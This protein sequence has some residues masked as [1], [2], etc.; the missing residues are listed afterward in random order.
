[1]RN[2]LPKVGSTL[3]AFLEGNMVAPAEGTQIPLDNKN[4][5]EA[6]TE[7]VSLDR[8]IPEDYSAY[9]RQS[10]LAARELGLLPGQ[11]GLVVNGRVSG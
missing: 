5:F 2:L 6:L 9:V 3:L 10:Q 11:K 1:M 4:P 8:I 7:G